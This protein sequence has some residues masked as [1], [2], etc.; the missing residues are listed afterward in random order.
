MNRSKSFY[1]RIEWIAYDL[2]SGLKSIYWKLLDNYTGENIIHGH[3]DIPSQG[4]AKVGIT[5]RNF[6]LLFLLYVELSVSFCY[7]GMLNVVLCNNKCSN[8]CKEFC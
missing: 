4:G 5:I 1:C 7:S 2:H 6:F 8:K 3:E